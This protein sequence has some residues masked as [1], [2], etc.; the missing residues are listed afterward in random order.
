MSFSAAQLCYCRVQSLAQVGNFAA[1]L[2]WDALVA[3]DVLEAFCRET[4]VGA[5][6]AHCADTL[7]EVDDLEAG[8]H[9]PGTLDLA[10]PLRQR[11]ARQ[12]ALKMLGL[13]KP[14]GRR[15]LP[16]SLQLYLAT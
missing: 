4:L 2:T 14:T 6:K 12:D 3:E 5:G 1:L 10:A 11:A 9:L 7:G 15:M 13:W 8:Q 16:C